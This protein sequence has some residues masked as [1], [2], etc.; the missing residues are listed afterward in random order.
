MNNIKTIFAAGALCVSLGFGSAMAKEYKTIEIEP[1]NYEVTETSSTTQ[2][3][4]DTVK[5]KERCIK[6]GKI[7][8]AGDIA[9]RDGCLISNY[10][11]K[12]NSLSF[13][14]LCDRGPGTTKID[15]SAE[16]SGK[17]KKEFAWKKMVNTQM[18][19]DMVFSI[20]STGKAVRTGDC[21]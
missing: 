10:K 7:D 12:G 18:S 15:G 8:P 11:T 20:S 16:Y 6:D 9:K 4:K 13:D 21:K 5:K 1:G 17:G 19:E 3:P 14:F 2:A